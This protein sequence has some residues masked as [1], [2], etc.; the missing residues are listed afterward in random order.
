MI[1]VHL[2][3]SLSLCSLFGKAQNCTF[4]IGYASCNDS[5]GYFELNCPLAF[6]STVLWSTGD[7]TFTVYVLPGNYTAVVTDTVT[8]LV[9]HFNLTMYHDTWHMSI[10][11][12]TV[13]LGLW[14][15]LPYCNTS[16]IEG[17]SC[18]LY[19]NYSRAYAIIWMDGIPIDTVQH[20]NCTNWTS[21]YWPRLEGH[22]YD[23]SVYDSVCNCFAA[24][25]LNVPPQTLCIPFTGVTGLDHPV[26]F[27][28]SPN[29]LHTTAALNISDSRFKNAELKIYNTMGSLVREEEISNINSYILQRD[30]L[31]DGLYFYEL[32]TPDS[33]LIGVGKFVI[34]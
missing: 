22:C 27:T 2:I 17:P 4:Y 25:W 31:G 18:S 34:E 23:L 26:H 16:L 14:A 33:E 24:T 28:F 9:E 6:E 1:R 19:P 13:N 11:D 8:G 21:S 7:T 10:S 12:N 32:L 5:L 15:Y 29:P 30:D 3:I 20:V